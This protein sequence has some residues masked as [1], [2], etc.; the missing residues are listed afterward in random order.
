MG[1]GRLRKSQ[2]NKV[3]RIHNAKERRSRKA[4]NERLKRAM[5]AI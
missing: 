3:L 2:G 5:I 4:C 1:R